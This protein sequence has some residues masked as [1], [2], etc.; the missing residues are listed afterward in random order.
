L[1]PRRELLDYLLIVV[2]DILSHH[3]DVVQ[4]LVQLVD[5]LFVDA[6]ETALLVFG[7]SP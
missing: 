5:T 6:A 1:E 7:I 2:G 3:Y 4:N